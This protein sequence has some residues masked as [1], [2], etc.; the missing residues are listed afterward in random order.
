MSHPPPE[1]LPRRFTR[2]FHLSAK[3]VGARCNLDCTYCYYLHKGAAVDSTSGAVPVK[4]RISDELLDEFVR[5]YITGQDVEEI[6]FTWHGG[7]PT[8][9]GLDFF[10]KVVQLQQKYAGTKRRCKKPMQVRGLSRRW[11]GRLFSHGGTTSVA[12]GVYRVK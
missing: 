12:S 9:L 1:A 4:G 6:D 10:R 7:E 3:P 11:A 2:S 5:Q 8:L